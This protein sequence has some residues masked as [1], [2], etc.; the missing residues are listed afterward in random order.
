MHANRTPVAL[1]SMLAAAALLSACEK[2]TTVT[3]TAPGSS[4]T[5]TTTTTT[6]PAA[7]DAMASTANTM[8]KAASATEQA[9]GKAGDAIGDAAIT[10]KVKTAL[11]ADP[12]VKALKIDV[13]T[14]DHVVSLNGTADTQARADKAVTIAQGVEGVKSVQNNLTVK[15]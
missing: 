2:K 3:D 1:V 14:K 10:G 11:I 15:P 9:M 6:A 7:S 13:D 12:D 5:T 8:E 4:S